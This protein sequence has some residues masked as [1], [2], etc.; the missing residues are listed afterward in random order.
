MRLLTKCIV[1]VIAGE[2]PSDKELGRQLMEV[3][4][5]IPNLD[6]D[7]ITNMLNSHMQVCYT[8]SLYHITQ[9]ISKLCFNYQ[10]HFSD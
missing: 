3:V 1:Q 9:I 7:T 5:S 8:I 6:G 10:N 2:V 4:Q